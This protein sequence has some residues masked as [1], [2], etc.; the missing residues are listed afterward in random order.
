MRQVELVLINFII[1]FKLSYDEDK[2]VVQEVE[3]GAIATME[4][5]SWVSLE[6]TSSTHD[7]HGHGRFQDSLCC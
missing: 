4:I 6:T 1:K 2:L 7:D 5:L 3:Q